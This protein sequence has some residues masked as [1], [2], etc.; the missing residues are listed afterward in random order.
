MLGS[1]WGGCTHAHVKFPSLEA[2]DADGC[3]VNDITS[4]S[5]TEA[6]MEECLCIH[7]LGVGLQFFYMSHVHHACFS[8]SFLVSPNLFQ[9][10]SHILLVSTYWKNPCKNK[11]DRETLA[12][13]R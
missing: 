6:S 13:L 12:T 7:V 2:S 4:E 11:M 8:I 3:A 10:R 9:I 5:S 1:G